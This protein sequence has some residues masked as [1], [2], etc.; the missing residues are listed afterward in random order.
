MNTGQVYLP[1]V[2]DPV[3]VDHCVD[4]VENGLVEDVR[5]DLW[6][7]HHARVWNAP[8]SYISHIS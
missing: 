7:D 1:W 2:L 8:V 5:H 6:A 3:G 4:R